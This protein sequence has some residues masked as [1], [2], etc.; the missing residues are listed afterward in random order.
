MQALRWEK[1]A[2]TGSASA[3]LQ[4]DSGSSEAKVQLG[5]SCFSR[6]VSPA[7]LCG[8]PAGPLPAYSDS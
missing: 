3:L 2:V 1:L 5:R 6:R 7:T 4:T 8:V